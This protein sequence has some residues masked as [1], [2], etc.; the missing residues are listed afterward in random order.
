MKQTKRNNIALNEEETIFLA[1]SVFQIRSVV[2]AAK[3]IH[4]LKDEG[5]MDTYNLMRVAENGL[6]KV[7]ELFDEKSIT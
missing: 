2:R 4:D 1:D 6:D 5:N 3:D 7:L